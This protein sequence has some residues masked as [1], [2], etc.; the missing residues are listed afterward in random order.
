MTKPLK[1]AFLWHMHQPLY[2]ESVGGK[3]LLPWVRLHAIKGY[4]D[5]PSVL[6]GHPQAKAS[7]NLT[8]SLLIQL[9]EYFKEDIREKDEFLRVTLKPA[10]QLDQNEN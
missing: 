1:V 3:F 7:F 8:P 10:S 2:Q 4:T 5:M 9:E 6:A